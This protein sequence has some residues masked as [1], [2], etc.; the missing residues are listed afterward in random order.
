MQLS[1]IPGNSA[2]HPVLYQYPSEQPQQP[3]VGD[4]AFLISMICISSFSCEIPDTALNSASARTGL[5]LQYQSAAKALK[6][7]WEDSRGRGDFTVDGRAYVSYLGFEAYQMLPSR[8]PKHELSRS[9]SHFSSTALARE[10]VYTSVDRVSNGLLFILLDS[11]ERKYA[12]C[13]R[14]GLVE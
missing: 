3:E 9:I 13:Q 5:E 11:F 14:I 6:E 4:L 1:F 7:Y 2:P 12:C 8:F 10:S